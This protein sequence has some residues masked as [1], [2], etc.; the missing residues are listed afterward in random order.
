MHN[1]W[2]MVSFPAKHIFS[3]RVFS[4]FSNTIKGARCPKCKRP[5]ERMVC[6]CC[7]NPLPN[8]LLTGKTGTISIIGD[9]SSG[10][11]VYFLALIQQL[12]KYAYKLGIHEVSP[13]DLTYDNNN[14]EKATS[15]VYTKMSSELF[16]K[17]ALP[18]QTTVGRPIPLIFRIAFKGKTKQEDRSILLVFY[19]AA[20]EI[21]QNSEKVNEIATYLKDSAGVIFLIDPEKLEGLHDTLVEGGVVNQAEENFVKADPTRI[22]DSLSQITGNEK[23]K[24]KP[25]ALTYSKIDEVV[26]A[27]QNNNQGYSIQG[28]N[29]LANSSFIKTGVFD[30]GEV[31][32]IHEGL[33]NVSEQE[34]DAG[35]FWGQAESKYENGFVRMFAVSALGS[36]PDKDGN[37]GK[38]KPYR[39]M[40]PLIW[41]LYKIGFAIPVKE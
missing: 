19:D 18:H 24:D 26:T 21:F 32:M 14:P 33:K 6:P 35:R 40:D 12:K 22:F 7:H 4:L 1:H 15:T 36:T 9:R 2:G 20:G 28:V 25:L 11:T 41:M 38:P 30:L 37:I 39:V 5:T 29:L 31:E 27:L 23:L 17:H 34:W 16:D 3:A 8:D 13:L 10:K